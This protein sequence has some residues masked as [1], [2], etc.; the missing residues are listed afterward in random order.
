MA[1]FLQ[2]DNLN[3]YITFHIPFLRALCISCFDD[4]IF[5]SN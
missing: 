4:L 3:R 2:S 5:V 1:L